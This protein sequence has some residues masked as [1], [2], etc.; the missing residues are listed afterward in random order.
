MLGH[1][2]LKKVSNVVFFISYFFIKDYRLPNSFFYVL[3]FLNVIETEGIF[4]PLK[5]FLYDYYVNFCYVPPTEGGGH[6]VF[7]AVPV[8]VGVGVRVRVGVG[9]RIA[10]FLRD[11]F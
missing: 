5:S 11:I 7:G 8:G 1:S 10:S 6:I 2:I 3:F 9:V 4:L